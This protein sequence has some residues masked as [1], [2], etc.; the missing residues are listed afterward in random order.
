MIDCVF[1]L[2]T[3]FMLV[4]DFARQDD[5]VDLKLPDIAAAIPDEN[6]PPDR[7]ILNVMKNGMLYC[8]GVE[9]N[10][11]APAQATKVKNLLWT[12]ARLARKTAT[13]MSSRVVLVRADRRC[14]FKYIRQL[15]VMCVDRN[16]QIWRLG[17][18]T[19]P[20][21]SRDEKLKAMGRFTTSS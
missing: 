10:M 7:L 4:L 15:M 21:E 17:F 12:E 2:N 6:P 8:G 13:G 16:I 14:P 11:N 9:Y 5:I 19:Q 3:F 18:G 20:F 1:L